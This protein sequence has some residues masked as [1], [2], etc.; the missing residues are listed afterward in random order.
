MASEISTTT[1]LD[2]VENSVSGPTAERVPGVVAGYT[3]RNGTIAV[4]AAGV[5][6]MATGVPMTEDTVFAIFSTTKAITAT[7]VLQL[8]EEG[9][10][11]LNAPVSDY[12]PELGEVGVLESF[13]DDG[14]MNTRQP[15]RPITM[16]D[17]LTHTAGFGYDFFSDEY[18]KLT[19]ELGYP[20]IITA[21]KKSIQTPLLFDPGAK[22]NYG[23][24]LDW[25]GLVVEAITG[26][27]LGDVF[28]ERIFGPLG[29]TNSSFK[30]TPELKSRLA[31]IHART[32]DG[33]LVPLDLTPPEDPEVHMGGHGVLSTVGDY[34]KFIRMWLNDGKAD[35]GTVILKPETVELALENH[36][37]GDMEVTGLAT[38][39]P[40]LSNDAEFFP[41]QKKTWSLGFMRNEEDAFSGRPAGAQAWAGLANLFYWIDRE[42]GIG[43]YWATQILPFADAVSVTD[44]FGFETAAYQALNG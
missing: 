36:L 35:D 24:N 44:Y 19:S 31:T 41:G 21:T 15:A 11:D 1:G 34:L 32:E 18:L 13:N 27:L 40:S 5:R 17:L 12:L 25:A 28:Q 4:H 14:T 6:D 33:D 2:V 10:L 37:P 30:L 43:G 16:T 42:N 20:S 29:M 38:S 7:A 22:W 26:K 9:K 39:I 23:V 3:D 8:V